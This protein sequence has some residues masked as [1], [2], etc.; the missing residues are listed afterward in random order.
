MKR[1]CLIACL[2]ASPLAAQSGAAPVFHHHHIIEFGAAT[3]GGDYAR[4]PSQQGRVYSTASAI[5][6]AFNGGQGATQGWHASYQNVAYFPLD[7]SPRL[8]L[9]ADFGIAAAYMPVDWA[10]IYQTSTLAQNYGDIIGDAS[11]G[12]MLSYNPIG[13]LVVDASVRAG[14][15]LMGLS[16]MKVVDYALPDGSAVIVEDANTIPATGLATA[17]GLR[18]RYSGFTLGWEMHRNAGSRTRT[19]TVTTPNVGE[20]N[21]FDYVVASRVP[22]SRLSF[23]FVF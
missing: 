16:R 6:S 1:T 2:A 17:F 3:P 10:T 4:L 14:Y 20:P 8:K 19:Y 11:I 13:R 12:P 9:G 21:D 15:G 22:T 18:A 7:F 5:S 23:G